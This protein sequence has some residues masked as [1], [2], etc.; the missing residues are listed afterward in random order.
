MPPIAVGK[1]TRAHGVRGEVGVLVLSEVESRF[2]R[3]SVLRLENGRALT[4]EEARRHR[5]GLLV[6]FVEI[7]DRTSAEGLGGRY[8]FVQESEVPELPQGSF[9]PHQLEGCEVL[10]ESGRSLGVIE[11]VIL[12]VANDIWVTRS[13]DAEV[14]VPALKDIVVSVDLEARRVVV[15]EVRGLTALP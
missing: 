15:R 6:S 3:G 11:E 7:A 13:G 8:L 5:G 1:I 12:G 2:D 14:L 4:V 9:W 10:T